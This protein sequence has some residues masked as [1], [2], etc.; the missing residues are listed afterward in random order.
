MF[1]TLGTLSWQHMLES[2]LWTSRVAVR[3]WKHAV[4]PPVEACIIA[5]L[6]TR[7]SALDW[8]TC[9]VMRLSATQFDQVACSVRA[10][11][12]A[13]GSSKHASTCRWLR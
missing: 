13:L 7:I 9:D 5:F 10:T 6:V 1:W 11:A 4:D 3:A 12:A 2:P 8:L